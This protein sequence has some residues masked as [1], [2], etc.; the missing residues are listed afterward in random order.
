VAEL[1]HGA[2]VAKAFNTLFGSV[3]ADP[4]MHGT[5]VDA[6]YATD[7]EVAGST[8]AELATSLGFRPVRVGPL[9]SAQELEAMAWLNIRLQ[10]VSGGDWRSSFVLVGAPI[11]SIAA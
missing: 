3:Q 2:R 9:A 4:Q 11:A 1:L 6:L 10:M 7:D 5:T 8:V